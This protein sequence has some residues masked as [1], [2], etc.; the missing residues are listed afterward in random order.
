MGGQGTPTICLA[1][2][3][4]IHGRIRLTVLVK[5]RPRL[6]CCHVTC[7]ILEYRFNHIRVSI[8][9]PVIPWKYL[10]VTANLL[11]TFNGNV[12]KLDEA[13]A[14]FNPGGR[15]RKENRQRQQETEDQHDLDGHDNP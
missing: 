15:T 8:L 2:T 10:A 9:V 1:I 13:T 7:D 3:I 12:S 4:G 5:V 14:N 11:G 6:L